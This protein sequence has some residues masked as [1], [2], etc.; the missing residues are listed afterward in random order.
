MSSDKVASSPKDLRV[1]VACSLLVKAPVL[2]VKQAML[3]A[4]FCKADATS[5]SKQM[6]IQRRV[7]SKKSMKQKQVVS[8]QR[9]ISDSD[10]YTTPTNKEA[11]GN[12]S[13]PDQMPDKENDPSPTPK[14]KQKPMSS[15]AW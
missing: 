10:S 9:S 4:G 15:Q 6:W 1:S 5:L 12:A 14:H 8:S 7:T 13:G 2:S 11:T 3:A